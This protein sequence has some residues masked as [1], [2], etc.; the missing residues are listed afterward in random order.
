MERQFNI[1]PDAGLEESLK[2]AKLFLTYCRSG[3]LEY[4]HEQGMILFLKL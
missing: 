2:I 4:K 1:V 3:V